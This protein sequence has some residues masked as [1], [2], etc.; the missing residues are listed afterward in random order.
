[1][2]S[3]QRFLIGLALAGAATAAG[4]RLQAPRLLAAA[5]APNANGQ[6]LARV[7]C[8]A[9]HKVPAPDILPRVAWAREIE[10]MALILAGK[11]M[12][13]WGDTTPR[14]AL[15]DEYKA[16]LA[17]YEA[18]APVALPP[19][20]PW[21]APADRPVRFVRRTITFKDALTPEPAVANV[22]DDAGDRAPRLVAASHLEALADGVA[23]GEEA[24]RRRLV[25][26]DRRCSRR[27][28]V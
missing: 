18:A 26:E 25:E 20:P 1:M 15:S 9:C 27:S 10:K 16:I 6:A 11:G 23:G 4:P 17:Y 19:L 21:P 3:R 24:A 7:A 8:L 14:V 2:T 22:P 13:E 28:V 5:P 12:P